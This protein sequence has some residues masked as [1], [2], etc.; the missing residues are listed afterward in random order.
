MGEVYQATDTRLKRDVAIKVLPER[1]SSDEQAQRR[2]QREALA[3]ANLSHPHI[4][5]I[6]DVGADRGISYLVMELLAGEPLAARVDRGALPVHEALR[7]GI[8][9]ADALV[10][11][12]GAGV[13]HRDLKPHNVMITPHGAKLLD[14]GLARFVGVASD[15][16]EADTLTVKGTVLGTLDHMAPEQLEGKDADQRTDVFALGLILYEMLTGRRAFQGQSTA[17]VVASILHNDPARVAALQPGIPSELD[18]LIHDCLAKDPDQRP[19]SAEEVRARLGRVRVEFSEGLRSPTAAMT[20]VK[21]P[22]RR[23][24]I[25]LTL[26]A[27]MTIVLIAAAIVR[28]RSIEA[29]VPE[30]RSNARVVRSVAVLPLKNLSGDPEQQYVADGLTEML[31]H[32]LSKIGALRVISSTSSFKYADGKKRL[33]EIAR[34]LRVDGIVEA[35]MFSA[36]P[37]VRVV[38]KL[39]DG[40][41][42]SALWSETFERRSED[43]MTLQH[44]LAAAIVRSIRGKLTPQEEKALAP[45]R[46]PLSESYRA[47]LKGRY[48]WNKRTPESLQKALALYEEALALDPNFALAHAGLADYYSALPFYTDVPPRDVF[49]S[50]KAAA[51]RALALDE[52][53]PEAHASMAYVLCYYD[54]EWTRAEE[55]FKRALALNPSHANAH[56]M[57][58]RFL[59]TTGRIDEAIEQLRLARELDPLATILH[60]NEG[61][62]LYFARRYDEAIVRLRQTLELDP[63]YAVAMW[64]IGLA[65]D[66]KG[67]HAQAVEWMEQAVALRPTSSNYQASLAYAYGRAGRRNDAA[68]IR[69]KL[70]ESAA[71]RYVSPYQFALIDAGLGDRE[72]VVKRLDE[73]FRDKSTLLTYMKMDPRLDLVREDPRFVE[74]LRKINL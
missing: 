17:H 1:F 5:S 9:I 50:A 62:I 12:H 53:L 47:Y 4:C 65:Y 3:I 28:W 34:E 36:G 26:A 71:N 69:K 27:I 19:Q 22:L 29:P 31:I 25:A 18:L 43:V 70:Q 60:A 15:R 63:K 41:T 7:Y 40:P 2:F 16:T 72:R 44:E 32:E 46:P 49:P 8:Q 74:L 57:Y 52:E 11:A 13:I 54:W 24:T 48:E 56:H 35:S 23:R 6:H 21:Q 64:G 58:S 61:V 51:T 42:E 55:H 68:G 20:A 73:A 14:F 37:R 66:A 33:P 67:D 59:S 30:E 39:L 38:A 10:A 45:P